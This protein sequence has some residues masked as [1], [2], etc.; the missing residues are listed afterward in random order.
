LTAF[1]IGSAFINHSESSR[2]SL[3]AGKQADLVVFDRDPFLDAGFGDA[4]VSMTV[5]SGEVVYED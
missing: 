4:R 3:S 2:G 5:V 1:T